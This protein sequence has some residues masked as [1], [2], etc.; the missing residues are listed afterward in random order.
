MANEKKS[1]HEISFHISCVF[2]L[3]FIVFWLERLY[4][5][6]ILEYFLC[7]EI[8]K[9]VLCVFQNLTAS[10][11][12]FSK[13]SQWSLKVSTITAWW[14]LSFNSLFFWSGRYFEV[15]VGNS[16][17]FMVHIIS[18]FFFCNARFKM[19]DWLIFFFF[20]AR[21]MLSFILI[22]PVPEPP[23]FSLFLTVPWLSP[24]S[25]WKDGADYQETLHTWQA[26]LISITSTNIIL[27][28]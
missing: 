17:F 10:N 12:N 7:Y 25:G 21:K 20:H 18:T 22:F 6:M 19:L 27:Y 2:T 5:S 15:M 8:A 3:I 26:R 13:L 1:D 11:K 14:Y 24:D 16:V 4:K 28:K 9:V 23:T